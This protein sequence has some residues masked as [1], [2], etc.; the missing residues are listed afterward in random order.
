MLSLLRK[1]VVNLSLIGV[2][3]F[4]AFIF[5][6]VALHIIIPAQQTMHIRDPWIGKRF[7][8]NAEFL[9]EGT[10]ALKRSWVG[11]IKTNSLGWNSVEFSAEKSP[12]TT[13]IAHI[14]D[15]ITE[16][17][18]VDTDKTFASQLNGLLIDT[19]SI[20]L[21]LA[22]NGT[23]PELLT[24]RHYGR[25]YDPDIVM[26]WF[27]DNDFRDNFL[28]KDV[29]GTDNEKPIQSDNLGWVKKLLLENLRSPRILYGI[30]FQNHLVVSA[31]INMGLLSMEP[32]EYGEPVPLLYRTTVLATPERKESQLITTKLLT[33]L[34]REVK[35]DGKKLAIGYVASYVETYPNTDDELRKLFPGIGGQPIEHNVPRNTMQAI[36]SS[37]GVPFFDLTDTFKRAYIGGK[38]PHIPGDGHLALEGHTLVAETLAAWLKE[39]KLCCGVQ[40]P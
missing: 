14:G 2:G 37:L 27:S 13:R 6:E 31:L 29:I 10:D 11:R 18:H 16:G 5:I 9:S 24:Y 26:L 38:T 34:A 15:S 17:I 23:Y 8:P 1:A 32:Q 12:E 40:L 19:E 30:F 25:E 39:R 3:I 21:G 28:V 7:K 22:G 33:T 36:T 20:N 35:A 4:L